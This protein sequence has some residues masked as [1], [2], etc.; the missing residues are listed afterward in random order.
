MIVVT[1]ELWPG[2][3]N[4]GRKTLGRCI[5]ANDGTGEDY[6]GNYTFT[7]SGKRGGTL[8]D[9]EVKA[10]PRRRKDVWSLLMLCLKEVCK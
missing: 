7:L 3:S 2:G 5:I 10:F 1:V 4:V 9:G 6:R 8:R